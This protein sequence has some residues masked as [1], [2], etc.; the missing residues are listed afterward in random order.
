MSLGKNREGKFDP[1]G[2]YRAYSI[3]FHNPLVKKPGLLDFQL[4]INGDIF[5]RE[6][7]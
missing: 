7:N 5:T 6:I 4:D 2:G 1:K 3:I